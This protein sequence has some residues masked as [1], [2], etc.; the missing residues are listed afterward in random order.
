[1]SERT[2]NEAL[3]GDEKREIIL[4]EIEKRL[5]GDC[6]LANDTAHGRFAFQ[7][8]L[9]IQYTQ[10]KG[11]TLVW[12]VGGSSQEPITPAE[13]GESTVIAGDYQS[14]SSPDVERQSHDLPIPVL[15]QTPNGPRREKVRIEKVRR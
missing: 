12:G 10:P 9:K 4:Q 7:F 1:M 15:V 3:G 13:I 2:L 6:T 14:A 11:E 8:E 5:K